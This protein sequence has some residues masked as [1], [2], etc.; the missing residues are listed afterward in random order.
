MFGFKSKAVYCEVSA[1]PSFLEI[2]SFI[3]AQTWKAN[4][5]THNFFWWC[6][7][8]VRNYVKLAKMLGK[9]ISFMKSPKFNLIHHHPLPIHQQQLIFFFFI[10][11]ITKQNN[12]D[13]GQW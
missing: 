9:G 6:D 12:S 4:L 11:K 10:L 2:L 8:K 13:K 7:F 1:S 5:R 3:F